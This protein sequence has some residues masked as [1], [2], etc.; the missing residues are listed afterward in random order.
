M[1]Q[2]NFQIHPAGRIKGPGTGTSDS[3]LAFLSKGEYVLPKKAVD[4]VG[5]KTLD[6]VK[7]AA[8]AFAGKPPQGYALGGVVDMA[9]ENNRNNRLLSEAGLSVPMSGDAPG[10]G[11]VSGDR[12]KAVGPTDT[13]GNET[14]LTSRFNKGAEMLKGLREGPKKPDSFGA[15]A[16]GKAFG[17]FMSS[18]GKPQTAAAKPYD[19]SIKEYSAMPDYDPSIVPRMAGGGS[20]EEE[21]AKPGLWDRFTVWRNANKAEV[22]AANKP[23][24]LG[25]RPK[26]SSYEMRS[27]GQAFN[28]F[29]DDR[30]TAIKESRQPKMAPDSRPARTD[31]QRA[32]ANA[33]ALAIAS[34]Q[35]AGDPRLQAMMDAQ[36]RGQRIIST[37]KA[38][39][40]PAQFVDNAAYNQQGDY[41]IGTTGSRQVAPDMAWENRGQRGNM[42]IQAEGFQ[43]PPTYSTDYAVTNADGKVSTMNITGPNRRQGG[44]TMSVV[45]SQSVEDVNRQIEALRSLREARNPGITTGGNRGPDAFSEMNSAMR[46]YQSQMADIAKFRESGPVS[47]PNRPVLKSVRAA[48][49]QAADARAAAA[50]QALNAAMG[51][52]GKRLDAEQARQAGA[53]Q[54]AQQERQFGLQQAQLAETQSNNRFQQEKAVAEH[55]AGREDKERNWGKDLA[56]EGN[57]N[58]NT[59]LD[60]TKGKNGPTVNVAELMKLRQDLIGTDEF[61]QARP[62]VAQ[63]LRDGNLN[64]QDWMELDSIQKTVDRSKP[65]WFMSFFKNP[66]PIDE[67]VQRAY[68]NKGAN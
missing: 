68:G 66:M 57:D 12:F 47:T 26:D 24:M 10:A 46:Q 59:Y 15:E 20:P 5:K 49:E 17:Q 32:A 44:G 48:H 19:P 4:M 60:L 41:T 39:G 63:R 62:E 13:Y 31:E 18:F 67:A 11:M 38:L 14:S 56:K 1:P 40:A 33:Q 53:A 27:P 23:N 58:L 64:L 34:Q 52:G 16:F 42:A 6:K 36:N 65:G 43:G 54:A 3:I 50:E 28:Q 2:N 7:N 22:A 35:Q 61:V 55:L 51:M 29:V 21:A 25:V 8:N 45:P 9:N 37:D 30:R